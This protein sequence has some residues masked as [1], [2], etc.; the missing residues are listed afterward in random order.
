MDFDNNNVLV[1]GLARSGISAIKL[2]KNI[3]SNVIAYDSKNIERLKEELEVINKYEVEYHFGEFPVEVLDRI[4]LIVLSPGVPTD[5]QIFDI[6]KNKGI[7]VWSEVELAYNISYGRLVAITGTNG[8]TTT[9]TLVGEI[10][11]AYF[12]KVFVV[13]NIGLPFSEVALK[14]D[15][16]TVIVAEISSFQLETIKSFQPDISCILNITPDHL[17]RHKTMD[18]YILMK[19][20][21][22]VNQDE[23][24]ICVL[25]YDDEI[26]K[27]LYNGLT[28]KTFFFSRKHTLA[29]GV[30]L[31]NDNIVISNQGKKEVLCNLNELKMLGEHNIEN[32]MAAIAISTQLGVPLSIITKIVTT[33]TG[34][35]HRIEFV[36]NI[37]DIDFYND[38][39]ATNPDSAIAGI[40]A[41]VRKTILIAGGMDKKSD[42]DEWILSFDN[43]VKYLVLFGETKQLIADT[44]KK[45]GFNKI[46]MVNDLKEAVA[47][48]FLLAKKG[49]CIL[50]SP[51]C[52]SWDMFTSYEE[53]GK[54][55]KEY[56]VSLEE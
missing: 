14:T 53:R 25:N 56:V 9:T 12:E 48:S 17:N 31:E 10:M 29:E 20:Q 11:K 8:K 18:N 38:S 15:D 36:A 49:E 52:A 2:L 55:F 26:V 44:A 39:K 13:G 46:E 41:M 24:Q 37:N 43:K 19:K 33:F 4:C 34:V 23:N 27:E 42:F 51:A 22:L 45:Y 40:K 1:F 35:E 47:K 6:A 7:P 54:L 28:V 16:D 30:Y 50:L 3:G 32:I 21:I 5:L